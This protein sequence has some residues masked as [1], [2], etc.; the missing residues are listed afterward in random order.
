MNTFIVHSITHNTPSLCLVGIVKNK[1]Q[2]NFAL[3]DIKGM[4][5][6]FGDFQEEKDVCMASSDC[7]ART[8]K[9]IENVLYEVKRRSMPVIKV[10]YLGIT[11]KPVDRLRASLTELPPYI[12]RFDRMGDQTVDLE[13]RNIDDQVMFLNGAEWIMAS[14]VPLMERM[15]LIDEEQR[16]KIGRGNGQPRRAA[17]ATDLEKMKRKGMAAREAASK[18]IVS[19]TSAAN[20][21]L[22]KTSVKKLPSVKSTPGGNRVER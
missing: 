1:K 20:V 4:A 8:Q 15:D 11:E 10:S 14:A 17:Q 9:V 21:A 7:D 6:Y 19:R 2:K 5:D 16:K 18:V 3:N 22:L 12:L 13:I